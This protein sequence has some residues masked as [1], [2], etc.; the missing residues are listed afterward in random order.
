MDL[1]PKYPPS[2]ELRGR[3]LIH[4]SS[5]DK[6]LLISLKLN[7]MVLTKRQ[8]DILEKIVEEYIN[9]ALPVSSLALQKKHNFGIKPAA[10]RLEME[11]LTA[12]GYLRQPHTASGRVPTDKGYRFFVD[13]LLEKRVN[14]LAENNFLATVEKMK[15]ETEEP[16]AFFQALTRKLAETTSSLTISYYENDN[17][18]L[19]EGW[20]E[21]LEEPEFREPDCLAEL[22]ETIEN[23]QKI[24]P[25]LLQEGDI[26]EIFIG[27]E[28]P[29]KKAQDFGIIV[30]RCELAPEKQSIF[31][32]IGPQ[33][34]A[35]RK[36]IE[37]MQS[38]TK[39]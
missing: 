26:L 18:W 24:L 4:I 9:S 1:T 32:I 22:F 6:R 37:L 2:A 34:M 14:N 15:M 30:S 5:L 28:I 13:K 19:K 17:L 35:Y 12:Q 11:K 16:L 36:N 38:L 21:M 10:I 3:P 20:Q 33:R 27:R 7:G 25:K 8:E 23:W 29:F 39:I 31:T